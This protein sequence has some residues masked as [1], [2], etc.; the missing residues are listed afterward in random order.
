M[1]S[2]LHHHLLPPLAVPLAPDAPPAPAAPPRPL[3]PP[4]P[5]APPA[6]LPARP[7][8]RLP[9]APKTEP[10]R[11][12]HVSSKEQHGQRSNHSTRE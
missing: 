7:T 5:S 6:P 11:Q 4:R 1:T 12:T 3:A 10:P 9:S 2:H 8:Q